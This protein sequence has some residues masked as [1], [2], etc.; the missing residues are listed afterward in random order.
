MKLS[1]TCCTPVCSPAATAVSTL[2]IARSAATVRSAMTSFPAG[3]KSR[4]LARSPETST[5]VI[6]VDGVTKTAQRSVC[7]SVDVTVTY[8]TPSSAVRQTRPA[9]S[10]V[11]G[12]DVPSNSK[13]PLTHPKRIRRQ[14][15]HALAYI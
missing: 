13:R 7:L 10:R 2:P 5:V 1:T 3:L 14:L 12:L 6:V 15:Q 9:L 8:S 4:Y 11:A